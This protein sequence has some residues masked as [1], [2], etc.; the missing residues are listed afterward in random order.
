MKSLIFTKR[1]AGS[2]KKVFE[3]VLAENSVN[4]DPELVPLEVNAVVPYSEAMH[5]PPGAFELSEMLQIRAD[6]FLRQSAKFAE[7]VELKI[8][9]HAG[10]LR[11]TGRIEYDL[12]RAHDL[13]LFIELAAHLSWSARFVG[14]DGNS[15]TP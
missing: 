8:L 13:Q 9:W 1:Q 4:D 7:N 11:S 5:Y 10:K 2:E 15:L 14:C 3:R 12:E 6:D